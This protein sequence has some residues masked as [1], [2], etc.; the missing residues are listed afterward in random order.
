MKIVSIPFVNLEEQL[1][2]VLTHGV[3]SKLFQDSII[4]LGMYDIYAP[5]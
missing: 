3:S 1:V 2:D 5:T 4:K